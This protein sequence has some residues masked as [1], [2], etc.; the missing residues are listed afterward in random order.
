[1]NCIKCNQPIPLERLQVID[2][3]T[4]VHC[5][6]VRKYIGF[7]DFNHKTGG[8]AVAIDPNKPNAAENLRR[9]RRVYERK[10]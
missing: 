2:T 7:M 4:C 9:A 3:N 1:M 8:E 6:D 5:S 10:R